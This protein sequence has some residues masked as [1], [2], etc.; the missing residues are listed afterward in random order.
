MLVTTALL[1]AVSENQP[2]YGGTPER[3]PYD[4]NP[5]QNNPYS[6]PQPDITPY[7]G[8][9]SYPGGQQGYPGYG[10]PQQP[11]G[12]PPLAHWGWR[13]LAALI[14]SVLGIVADV[15]VRVVVGG[16]TGAALGLLVSVIVWIY[17]SYME[18]TTGQT[19][20]KKAVGTRTLREADGHVLGF[21]LAVGRRLLHILDALSCYVG[22]LWPLWD[23]KR[24]TFAD[25]I[26]HSVVIKP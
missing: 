6:Q 11:S 24:Q 25:K 19:P 1:T 8:D 13:V 16:N 3:D 20:G 7:P 21:G 2:P 23:D 15:I 26:V 12:M 17:F 10:Q 5:Y 18:G 14:D 4:R 9:Y 22:F